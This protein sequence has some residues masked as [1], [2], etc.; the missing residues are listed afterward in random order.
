MHELARLWSITASTTLSSAANTKLPESLADKAVHLL[1]YFKQP[2]VATFVHFS[3]KVPH[4]DFVKLLVATIPQLIEQG[5]QSFHLLV[6]G[7]PVLYIL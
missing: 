1:G 5:F 3:G 4:I 2:A 7:M 6:E